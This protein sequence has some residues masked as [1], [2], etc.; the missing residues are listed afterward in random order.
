LGFTNNFS[1]NLKITM[2]DAFHV[3]DDIT[4]FNALRGF[5][6]AA[7]DPS[8]LF[9]PVAVRAVSRN[10][11]ASVVTD[12]NLSEK[13]VLSFSGSHSLRDFNTSGPSGSLSDLQHI[14]GSV[15]LR[16]RTSGKDEWSAGYR[17]SYFAFRTFQNALSDTGYVG[18]STPVGGG[19]TLQLTVGVSNVQNLESR[20]SYV[21]YNTS[22]ILQKSMS[23]GSFSLQYR[24][25]S[26][27]ASGLGSISDTR[28]ARFSVR[29]LVGDVTVSGNL[30]AFESRGRLDNPFDANGIQADGTVGTRLTREWTIQGGFQY[31]QYGRTSLYA[32]DQKRVFVSLRY[33]NPTLFKFVR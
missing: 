27:E 30:A 28:E 16:R 24:Q 22:A 32:F 14:N 18:Y 23:S 31:Q 8:L 12:Y 15:T 21:G 2:S 6:P 10:N 4:T 5:T 3:T 1:K 11:N 25:S 9:N 29:H 26:G 7:E 20:F 33:D 19:F 17:A 13:S